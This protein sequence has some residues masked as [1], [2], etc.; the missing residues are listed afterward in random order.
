LFEFF[1]RPQRIVS[2]KIAST[3]IQVPECISLI[4]VRFRFRYF[5][6]AY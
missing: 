6:P 5:F 2:Q 4:C 1:T 3:Q